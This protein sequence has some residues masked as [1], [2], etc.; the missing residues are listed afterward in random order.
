MGEEVPTCPQCGTRTEMILDFSHT[1]EMTQIHGC[2]AA[3]CGFEF[4]LVKDSVKSWGF[5]NKMI[6]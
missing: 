5:D 2:L 1:S 4:V 6:G 3:D